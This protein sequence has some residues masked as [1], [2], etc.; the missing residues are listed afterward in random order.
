MLRRKNTQSSLTKAFLVYTYNNSCMCVDHMSEV[1]LIG[2]IAL[3]VSNSEI[4]VSNACIK[5][6]HNVLHLKT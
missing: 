4:K 6:L 5:L 3:F 2:G 1:K